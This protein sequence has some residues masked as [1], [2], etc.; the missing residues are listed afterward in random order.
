MTLRTISGNPAEWQFSKLVVTCLFCV[1]QL[2][3][4]TSSGQPSNLRFDRISTEKIIRAKGLSQNTI[5]CILQDS[6]GFMWMGTW[7]GLNRYD[8]YSFTIFNM[9]NGLSNSTIYDIVEDRSGNIWVAT[10]DGLN[11]MDWNGRDIEIFRHSPQEANSLSSNVVNH[12]LQ[13]RNGNLWICTSNGLNKY[14]QETGSFSNYNF[15]S[16]RTDRSR[17]NWV[18]CITE[19]SDGRL[20]VA[21]RYGLHCF[22]PEE[23]SF[24]SYYFYDHLANGD[25]YNSN[26]IQTCVE[27]K[28]GNIWA[29]TR[30]GIFVLNPATGSYNQLS[31]Q[32]EAGSG[33]SSNNVNAIYPGQNGRIWIGT[34]VGLDIYDPVTDIFTSYRSSSSTTSLSNDDIRSIFESDDGTIWVG[35]YKGLNKVDQSSSRFTHYQ[36]LPDE[37]N[38]LSDNIVY[39]VIEDRNGLVWIATYAGVNIL[40]RKTDNFSYL[41][42]D[43]ED[44]ATISNDRIRVLLEDEQGYIWI[45]TETNGLNRYDRQTGNI[46]KYFHQPGN[47]FT[48]PENNIVSMLQDSKERLW[49]GTGKGVA[50]KE[51]YSDLFNTLNKD[52]GPL[53]LSGNL[54]WSVYED[55]DGFIWIGTTTGLNR[56]DPDLRSI[57]YFLHDPSDPN[58]ISSNRVFCIY[59]DKDEI[60]WMGTMGGGLNRYDAR[61]GKFTVF[62]EKDGLPNNVVYGIVEDSS[63]N[64]W[65]STNWGLA[66]FDKLTE[67]FVKYDA[68]DGLQGNEFNAGAYHKNRDGEI[69]FGGMNGFNVFLPKDIK[70]NRN[71]PRIVITG[72]RI[73]N[74]RT[75]KEIS[76]GDTL[77]LNYSDNFFSFEFSALDYTNPD[78]NWYR[79]QLED[80]DPAWMSTGASRRYAQYQKVSP[81]TYVFHVT[82]TNNDGVWNPKGVAVTLIIRPPWWQ[83]WTFR[84]LFA[85]AVL[86]LSYGLA[87]WRLRYIRRKHEIE[88]K[89]LSIEKQIFDLEQKALRLQMNPHF[90]F[91]SLNAIQNFVITN[92][93]DKAVNY[94]AKFSHLMR[95]ILANSIQSYIPLK[96][97]LKALSYYMEL[98][99]LRFDD[100]FDYTVHIDPAIDME[101]IEVP[102]MLLQPYVE[103]AIIHGL[104]HIEGKGTLIVRIR[105][106]KDSLICMVEDNGIG[107]EK[108]IKLRE[109]SGINRQPRGMIITQERLEILNKQRKKGFSVKVTD[110]KDEKGEAA[111]TRVEIIIQYREV[112]E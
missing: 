100:K 67:T 71:I 20:W 42:H 36:H 79:Y 111:G 95:M 27:D 55:H 61:S 72:F 5:H 64:L 99:K 7:D 97:E 54:V 102:P 18:T 8:G 82:G 76:D 48:L 11:R 30:R 31:A 10:D 105:K 40:D 112:R 74:E 58:T 14:N 9:E 16:P 15:Y 34:D 51:K 92:D 84:I 53:R 60:F 108:A 87:Y 19:S 65:I 2:Y 81:G 83:T 62:T 101:F 23:E 85:L 93:T 52:K 106:K 80:F 35:T 90:I 96:D 50:W 33:L 41:K 13:D 107:R 46:K 73:F 66:R 26:T 89:M 3:S 21:T 32:P 104:V 22:S 63:G 57:V 56:L 78:K 86:S 91:N 69:Y 6:K 77:L 47:P 88:R 12:L 98:E 29:G 45:G 68:M 94:L 38:S 37:P 75:Y 110:L 1:I 25:E 70:V 28:E 4:I 24:T 49:V 43:P 59:Q 39:S 44:P 17:S 109:Q 103:N